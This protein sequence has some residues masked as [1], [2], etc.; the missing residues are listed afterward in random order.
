MANG[1]HEPVAEI[2]SLGPLLARKVN[3]FSRALIS[4]SDLVERFGGVFF[5]RNKVYVCTPDG[6]GPITTCIGERNDVRLYS[7][8]LK[9][10]MKHERLVQ[11]RGAESVGG[12]ADVCA[13]AVACSR[14]TGVASSSVTCSPSTFCPGA[15]TGVRCRNSLGG[16]T[17]GWSDRARA[18]DG[19]YARGTSRQ[20]CAGGRIA[21]GVS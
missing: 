3:S 5:D 13:T 4:V 8:D 19:V 10:L 6:V 1:A 11:R 12:F 9:A 21:L 18:H 14:G 2:G 7:F 15:P 16:T 20:Q 17:C